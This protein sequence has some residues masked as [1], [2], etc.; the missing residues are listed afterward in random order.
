[1]L[2]T[3][4]MMWGYVFGKASERF[5]KAE[6]NIPLLVLAGGLS[7]YDLF[8]RQPY[9]TLFGHHGLSHSWLVI[10]LLSSPF[11]YKFGR[12]TLPYFLAAIQHPV[13]GDLVT[14]H[15]PLLFP[16]TLSENGLNLFEQNP[17]AS[18]ALEIFGFILFLSYFFASGDW[19]KLVQF[20]IWNKVLL[21]LWLPP[22]ALTLL[23]A[24]WYY[25]SSAVTIIY[26]AYALASSLFLLA[27]AAHMAVPNLLRREPTK[28]ARC[29]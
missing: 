16:V 1:M 4:H 2:I 15:I 24:F 18:V 11:F 29:V 14:N 9:G 10:M 5:Q 25:Q 3:S 26:S 28:S 19:K 12:Q 13:F 22:L 7:D 27:I 23:Q 6:L 21:A 8:T 17:M 20:S